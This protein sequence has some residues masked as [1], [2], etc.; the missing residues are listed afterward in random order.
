[1]TNV[2]SMV[3]AGGAG[4][5][6]RPLTRNQAKPAVPIAGRYRIIDFVLSSLW[7]SV[8]HQL[9]V[10]T[11]YKPASLEHHL[12]RAWENRFNASGF[13]Q[14]C[15]ASE[16]ADTGTAGAVATQLAAIRDCR[17]DALAVVSADHIY[18]MDYRQM[19]QFHQQHRAALTIAAVAVPEAQASQFGI[20]EIDEHGRMTGFVE[21]PAGAVKCIPGRPGYVLA[22]MGNY[23][24]QPDCLYSALENSAFTGDRNA[25]ALDFGHHLIPALFKTQAVYVYDFTQNILPGYQSMTHYWRDVGTLQSYYQARMDLLCSPD[26]L[27]GDLQSWPILTGGEK[28]SQASP[29]F[30]PFK[31]R[32]QQVNTASPVS[33]LSGQQPCYC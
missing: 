27:T 28:L 20:I 31:E 14:I 25:P 21:K 11:Q 8:F 13:L 6:L 4:T 33:R 9:F 3:L 12:H 29:P 24:F 26:W 32:L 16:L 15:Q 19:L 5:R 22:S 10:L 18:K 23:I 1:M 17:P 2:V 30:V 7:H